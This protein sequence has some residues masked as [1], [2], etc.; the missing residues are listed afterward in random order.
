[1]LLFCR[2]IKICNN[3]PNPDWTLFAPHFSSFQAV[4][5]MHCLYTNA[6]MQPSLQSCPFTWYER[7]RFI[8]DKDTATFVWMHPCEEK[9]R[10]LQGLFDCPCIKNKTV[11]MD[12]HT[13][14]AFTLFCLFVSNWGWKCKINIKNLR[15][16]FI[17][18]LMRLLHLI[19]FSQEKTSKTMTLKWVCL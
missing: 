7:Q 1:M 12:W 9:K 4:S 2:Y 17:T 13:R 19:N 5:K 11:N 18:T 3:I 16:Y 6:V 14:S 10:W 15:N 8:L